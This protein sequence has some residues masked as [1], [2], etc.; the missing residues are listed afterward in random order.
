[1]KTEIKQWG[2]SA[3]VRLPTR[4]LAKA[5]LEINSNIEINAQDGEIVIRPARHQPEY[6][7]EELLA[8]SPAE[9][10][11][12]DDEDRAWLDAAPVGNEVL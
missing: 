4:L 7:L 9:S 12:L 3:A 11:E 6:T 5:G 8:A 10:F 1:M 2:N